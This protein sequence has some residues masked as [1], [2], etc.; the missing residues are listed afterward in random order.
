MIVANCMFMNAVH[1]NNARGLYIDP[2]WSQEDMDMMLYT[3]LQAGSM[4]GHHRIQL[5]TGIFTT[6]RL[7][8]KVFCLDYK[9]LNKHY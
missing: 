1:S 5:R 6:N 2:H 4:E 3:V 7:Y 8:H 9:P